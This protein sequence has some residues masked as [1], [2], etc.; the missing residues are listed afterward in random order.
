[1]VRPAMHQN[2]ELSRRVLLSGGLA[3]GLQ[4]HLTRAAEPAQ[5]G[6]PGAE[7]LRMLL[8]GNERYVANHPK[9]RNFDSGRAERVTGQRPFAAVLCCSDSR[10]APEFVFDEG[11]GK[12]FV[13]RVAGNV[14]S[15]DGL[16]SLEYAVKYLGVRLVM[17]LG[18]R[19]CGAVDAAIKTVRTGEPLPGHLPGLID[20]I[21]P[22][23]RSAMAGNPPDLLAAAIAENVR[24]TEQ[25]ITA[26]APVLAPVVASGEVKVAGGVYDLANGRVSLV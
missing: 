23:V 25:R 10:V 15:D 13:V 11:P 6:V 3:A 16:A 4:A 19:N 18:H 21:A 9:E 17:V 1:M 5:S 20:S 14:L 24:V 12:L 7:A 26:A 2:G 8:A 22:S